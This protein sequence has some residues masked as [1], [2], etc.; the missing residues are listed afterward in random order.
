MSLTTPPVSNA[1]T[2]PHVASVERL[3]R[4]AGLLYVTT[5]FQLVGRLI[6]TFLI[7]QFLGAAGLGL[8]SLGFVTTQALVMLATNGHDTAV[9]KFV[10]PAYKAGDRATVRRIFDAACITTIGTAFVLMLGMILLF[11]NIIFT[12]TSSAEAHVVVPLFAP[13]VLFQSVLSLFGAF[14]LAHNQL[15][16]KAIAEKVI[17]TLTQ[18]VATIILLQLGFGLQGAILALGL[19]VAVSLSASLWFMRTLY[20]FDVPVTGRGDAMR[21]MFRYAWKVGLSNAA[22]YVL[23]NAALLVLGVVSATQAGLYAAASRLTWI[24]LL[25][26]E[27]FGQNFAPLAA[28]KM[29]DPSLEN[30]LQRVTVWVIVLSAPVYALLFAFASQWMTLLGPE[31][32][33]AAPVLMVLA[34]AQMLNM[35]TGNAGTLV[36]I[37]NR[38]GLRILNAVVAWGT[39][40]ILVVWLAVPYGALGAAFAYLC[41]VI[42]VDTLEYI[43]AR[44]VVGY[45][46]WG[47]PMAKPLLWIVLLTGMLVLLNLLFAPNVWGALFLSLVFIGAYVVV[48][49]F[50]GLPSPDIVLLRAAARK[51][52]RTFARLRTGAVP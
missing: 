45:S 41:A 21:G 6:V 44:F 15:H 28:S 3:V 22:G 25:F 47:K 2:T 29:N 11:P 17:G 32:A 50:D 46:P 31:F 37:S 9:L 49:W 16:I 5:V 7:A 42:L 19:S 39:N 26:L 40:L 34:F 23:L 13:I 18:I 38:P 33:G 35:L 1:V 14:G 8:F 51:F 30:D 24:G 10:S 48:M 4:G 12:A 43:E 36:T 27:A 52:L 20:P